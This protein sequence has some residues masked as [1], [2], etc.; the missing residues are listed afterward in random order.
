MIKIEPISI[1]RTTTSHLRRLNTKRSQHL[2]KV[3]QVLGQAQTC[4]G[5]K[6]VTIST[7]SCVVHER[8]IHWL[9]G[10][11][12]ILFVLKTS[13]RAEHECLKNINNITLHTRNR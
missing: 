12:Q 7:F 11:N 1:L 8:G 13:R 3:I 2:L 9:F 10:P 6:L 5:V 4:G